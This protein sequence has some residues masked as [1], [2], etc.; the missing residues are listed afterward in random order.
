MTSS[1]KLA[2][3][4]VVFLATAATSEVPAEHGAQEERPRSGQGQ[5]EGEH[6][7]SSSFLSL[8]IRLDIHVSAAIVRNRVIRAPKNAPTTKSLMYIAFSPSL[9]GVPRAR[10]DRAP[11]RRC[12]GCLATC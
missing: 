2:P 5:G 11:S 10:F 4:R 9:S 1:S 12:R 7:L 8:A 6:P 3:W